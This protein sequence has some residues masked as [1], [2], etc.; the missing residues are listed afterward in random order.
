[1]ANYSVT[2]CA[3]PKCSG[4][5][6]SVAAMY[7]NETK[8]WDKEGTFSGT[9]I[10][11]GTAGLGVGFGGGSYSESGRAASMRA[12]TFAE[13]SVYLL[14]VGGLLF[15]AIISFVI[16]G[17]ISEVFATLGV[18]QQHSDATPIAKIMDGF[19]PYL[20]YVGGFVAVVLLFQFSKGAWD[21]EKENQRRI[22]EVYP[23]LLDRYNELRYCEACN[24]LFD[25]R[26]NS[27]NANS[28]GFEQMLNLPP[29]SKAN[30]KAIDQ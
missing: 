26:G 10:G 19:L 18:A 23:Q 2:K 29:D 21:N 11:L 6:Q 14:P 27:A 16:Y 28:H 13:P 1:M 30:Q 17:N 20:K 4:S 12:E 24:V 8:V 9:G 15:L 3:C 7:F 25:N 22:T 5:G